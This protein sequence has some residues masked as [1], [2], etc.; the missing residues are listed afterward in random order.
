MNNISH[1][2]S[3]EEFQKAIGQWRINAGEILGVFNLYGMGGYI[4][5]A[6]A[7][8][9]EIT[10]DFSKRTRGE[11]DQPIRVKNRRNPRRE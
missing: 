1:W 9:E 10:I 7:E 3:D 2:L 11:K 6:L 5:G 8:L 4:P